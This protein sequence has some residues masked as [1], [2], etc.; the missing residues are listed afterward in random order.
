ML[1]MTLGFTSL[2]QNFT[3][4]ADTMEATYDVS[5]WPSDY[6]YV[7]NASGG[8]MDMSFDLLTNTIPSNSGWSVTLCT[9]LFC[10]PSVPST[11]SFGTLT[12]GAQGYFNVHVG[13]GGTP[14]TGEISFRI[15]ETSN[16]SNADTIVFIYHALSMADISE[17]INAG[18]VNTFPNPTTDV[19]NVEGLENISDGAMNI[20]SITGQLIFSKNI[21]AA[22]ETINVADFVN[23]VYF[24]EI[25][26]DGNTVYS[27]RFIKN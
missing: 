9:H 11:D 19:I 27:T 4:T 15:Y 14:G 13:F 26:E 25:Q 1:V 6:N 21:T 12:D 10:M 8:S 16:P 24:M 7:V 23:G 20:Y 2:A 22:T 5:A 17:N 3:V 18:R